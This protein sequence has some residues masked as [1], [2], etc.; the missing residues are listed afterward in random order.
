VLS[1]YIG[2]LVN[3][4]MNHKNSL[5]GAVKASQPFE[6]QWDVQIS[7]DFTSLACVLLFYL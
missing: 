1:F 4:G 7:F 2:Y 6:A 3:Q 5:H